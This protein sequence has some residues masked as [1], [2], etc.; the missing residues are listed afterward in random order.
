MPNRRQIILAS[1]AILTVLT[2]AAC[3]ATSPT[4]TPTL[5][6]TPLPTATATLE[7]TPAPTS[8]LPSTPVSE[9]NIDVGGYKLLYQCFGQGTPTVI[10][11]AGG[12]DRPIDRKSVV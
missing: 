1:V 9:G 7:N 6:N 12:G 5:K 3:V 2:V 4:V 8:A 10:I 11:E